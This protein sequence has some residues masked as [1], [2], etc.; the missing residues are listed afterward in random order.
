MPAR[1]VPENSI[2]GAAEISIEKPEI[3]I[4]RSR[5]ND[6]CLEDASVSRVHARIRTTPD[7]YVIEDN[8]SLHGTQVNGSPITSRRLDDND[9]IDVGIYRFR[10]VQSQVARGN[11]NSSVMDQVDHL[12]LLLEVTKLINSSLDLKD[13]LEH[14]IDAVIRVTRAERGFLM[15]ISPSDELEFRVARNL[16]RTALETND[17]AV[18]FSVVER[19]RRTGIPVVVS[20]TLNTEAASP[21]ASIVELGLRSIMCVPL[22]TGAR[23][24]GLIYVDSHRQAKTLRRRRSRAVSISGKPGRCS[25]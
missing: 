21:S 24:A 14:V 25:H 16:D 9:L 1:L 12:H 18:S 7:G 8:G 6:L 5:H 23:I 20:D 10:F 22:N 17:I 13:V 11:P 4:G 19:V 3:T 15:T 2:H